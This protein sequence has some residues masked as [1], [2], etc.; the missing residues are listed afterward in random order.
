MKERDM[1]VR[2]KKKFRVLRNEVN[3]LVRRDRLATNMETLAKSGEN[4]K[5]LWQLANDLLGVARQS[6]PSSLNTAA[7]PTS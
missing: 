3:R 7:G 5:V 2:G 6:L 1:A 4:P